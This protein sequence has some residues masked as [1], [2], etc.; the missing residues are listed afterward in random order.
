V[1]LFQSV[2][3]E[4]AIPFENRNSGYALSNGELLSDRPNLT[5]I[6]ELVG[7]DATVEKP[8]SSKIVKSNSDLGYS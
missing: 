4:T 6:Q 2:Y 7:V 8:I 1:D 3:R 5:G